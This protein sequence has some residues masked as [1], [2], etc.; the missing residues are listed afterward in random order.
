MLIQCGYTENPSSSYTHGL[1]TPL[2]SPPYSQ[3]GGSQH[4]THQQRHYSDMSTTLE[5]TRDLPAPPMTSK[6]SGSMSI[7]SMLGENVDSPRKDTTSRPSPS[8]TSIGTRIH[9]EGLKPPSPPP[10]IQGNR[11]PLNKILSPLDHRP[12]NDTTRLG[13]YAIPDTR[14]TSSKSARSPDDPR[15]KP[16]SMSHRHHYSLSPTSD[17]PMRQ[18][19]FKNVH[20]VTDGLSGG[21]L[22]RSAHGRSFSTQGGN[23]TENQ[24]DLAHAPQQPLQNGLNHQRNGGLPSENQHQAPILRGDD[25][26]MHP[27]FREDAGSSLDKQPNAASQHTNGDKPRIPNYPFLAR[28]NQRH[29]ESKPH[30][31]D[32]H[33]QPTINRNSQGGKL[34][35][36]QRSPE[37]LRRNQER[38]RAV[39]VESQTSDDSPTK[40]RSRL[41]HDELRPSSFRRAASTSRMGGERRHEI[42]DQAMVRT[43]SNPLHRT[44][45]GLLLDH[46]RRGRLSPLPQAVQGAQGRTS[47]P[48]SDKPGFGRMFSGLGISARSAGQTGSGASTPFHPPSPKSEHEPIRKSS[49]SHRHDL[50][51]GSKPRDDS[52]NGKRM[53]SLREDG[54]ELVH[55]ERDQS[56]PRAAKRGKA[57]HHHVMYVFC[58]LIMFPLLI[59]IAV[60]IITPLCMKT[61]SRNL[62]VEQVCQM[63]AASPMQNHTITITIITTIIIITVVLTG[64]K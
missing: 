6:S 40:L 42:G 29:S 63:G 49:L 54:D 51:E 9:V 39:E 60:I 21:V 62:Q 20:E 61:T 28:A 57:H 48:G 46:N 15:S 53:R 5:S 55:G 45:L 11:Y 4:P 38:D 18:S 3:L 22:H 17:P 44:S 64:M 27:K 59:Y 14:P 47:G 56:V 30:S 16:A 13:A 34:P 31:I 37:F 19:G 52:R 24:G 8:S 41:V 58:H 25:S 36:S 43:E 35:P 2:M 50:I 32:I 7:L 10:S 1:P 26:N 33:A 12:Y 23:H